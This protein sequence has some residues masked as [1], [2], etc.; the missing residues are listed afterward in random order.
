LEIP[1]LFV[2]NVV[3]KFLV[4]LFICCLAGEAKGRKRSTRVQK[5]GVLPVL[6]EQLFMYNCTKITDALMMDA[7]IP[8]R[9]L[10][11]PSSTGRWRR[12]RRLYGPPPLCGLLKIC[13]QV[14]EQPTDVR[15]LQLRLRIFFQNS[16]KNQNSLK[17]ILFSKITK[18]ASCHLLKG[19]QRHS[20]LLNERRGLAVFST[21]D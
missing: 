2:E 11:G 15:L 14:K 4:F 6:I 18:I 5:R 1:F 3:S 19:R 13:P 12:G 16:N 10:A 9:A 21:G 8:G 17:G 7:A 20:S